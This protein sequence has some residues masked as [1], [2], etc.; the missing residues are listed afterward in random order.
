[1]ENQEH[2]ARRAEERESA[3]EKEGLLL[4]MPS[5]TQTRFTIEP[6]VSIPIQNAQAEW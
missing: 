2:F 3:E 4:P 5:R 6:L 1:M